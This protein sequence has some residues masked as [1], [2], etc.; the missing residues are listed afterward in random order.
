MHQHQEMAKKIQKKI[1]KKKSLVAASEP[2]EDV[3][4]DN[5]KVESTTEPEV[6]EPEVD[7]EETDADIIAL[8]KSR[9]LLAEEAESE[10]RALALEDLEFRAGNQ[11]SED[12]KRSRDA[13]KRPC[14]VINRIPQ[15]IRQI[16]NDQRQN[17]PTIKISPVDDGADKETAKVRQGLVRH[18]WN[19]SNADVAIDVAFE[20]AVDKS[21][22]FFRITTD[23]VN[24][25]SFDQEILIKQ[26]PNH[27]SVYLD[28]AAKEPD[29][30][31]AKW[32]FVF[33]EVS[34]DEFEA[35]YPDAKASIMAEWSG[36]GDQVGW[37]D[38]GTCRVAE[39]FYTTYKKVEIVQFSNGVVLERSKVVLPLAEGV[40]ETNKR[41]ALVP[42]IK[43][44]KMTGVQIM[45]RRDW[46]GQWVPIIPVYGSQLN[47]NGKI[48]RES[49]VRHAK[50]PQKMYNY[51]V[52]SETEAIALA[53]KAPFIVAEGQIPP[54]YKAMWESANVK[55]HSHLIYKALTVGQQLV[56]AP[57]RNA[58]EPPVIAITNARGQAAD[59]IKATTGIFDASLGNR[60]NETSGVAIQRRNAQAQT[61][62]FHFFDNL[63]RSLKHAGKIIDDLIPYIYDAART[64]RIIGVDDQEEMV[65]INQQFEDKQGTKKKHI[66]N[67]GKYDVMIETG[68]N[69]ATKRQEAVAS[70]LDLSKALPAQ[71][72]IMADLLVKNMDWPDADIIAE[73]LKKSIDPKFLDDKDKPQ[74]E[75]PAQIQQKMAEM[76]Q[77][78]DQM[79]Q[80]L[81]VAN[82]QLHTKKMEI[83]SKERIAFA[84]MKTKMEIEAAKLDHSGH[85]TVFLQQVEMLNRRLDTLGVSIPAEGEE[86]S[87][88]QIDPNLTENQNLSEPVNQ[89]A[90]PNNGEF[91]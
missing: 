33:E 57:Q 49:I 71:A 56:G 63:T 27:F 20:G 16:C 67:A 53:P 42:S 86:V 47:I 81:Q 79:S 26:I 12:M 1:I 60:S 55:N 29:G 70:M 83:D 6:E 18:I 5:I 65:K 52:S 2:E 75:D 37:F 48:I 77:V 11:W 22:G 69:Y 68:P 54:E 7:E 40:K 35:M 66:M 30:S 41:V 39:Y 28:P 14:L 50:D 87:P 15:I 44:V 76:G 24:A 82:E 32:G 4:T 38:K 78:I 13:D 8:A 88:E 10:N 34:K 90:V 3:P 80:Q 36:I 72:G 51:F 74:G 84:E 62:N 23:Y 31:D 45:E 85:Q 64:I 21:F 73:R 58:Y 89:D 19:N 25:Q 91:Q 43:W 61:S 59:D 46:A 17:R 9:F